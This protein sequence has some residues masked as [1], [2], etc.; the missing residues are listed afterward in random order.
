VSPS[1][2]LRVAR[3]TTFGLVLGLP[4]AIGGCTRH[5]SA[6]TDPSP[7]GGSRVS[8]EEYDLALLDEARTELAGMLELLRRTAVKHP[9]RA[10]SMTALIRLHTAHDELLAES[11][12][13]PSEAVTPVSVPGRSAKALELVRTRETALQEE[14]AHLAGLVRSGPLARVLA[15]M[16]A[17]VA[18]QVRSLPRPRA[19]P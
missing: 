13:E 6:P 17:A 9:D 10:T 5:D 15:S 12:T 11:A 3:R 18:Q 14:L 8:D 4:L 7:D 1:R 2:P 19:A 16:S